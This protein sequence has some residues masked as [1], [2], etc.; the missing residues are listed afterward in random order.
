M[1][2]IIPVIF[3]MT[4]SLFS[5]GQKAPDF[6]QVVDKYFYTLP[7]DKNFE[8]WVSEIRADTNF[9][10]DSS[11]Y[12]VFPNDSM[13]FYMRVRN[14]NF[15]SPIPGSSTYMVVVA[16]NYN[17]LM[18]KDKIVLSAFMQYKF[19]STEESKK[20]IR[21]E[22]KFLKRQVAHYFPIKY[23]RNY[24]RNGNTG[25]MYNYYDKPS[26]F[27]QLTLSIGRKYKNKDEKWSMGI[28][29]GYEIIPYEN[30]DTNT[31]K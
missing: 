30:V 11:V 27:P 9:I 8:N 17:K 26:S 29:I 10:V 1:K 31:S 23:E 13:F 21:K 7:E 20:R 15:I 19:D 16:S 28:A 12:N 2:K 6:H 14:K 24:S 22:Y 3:I 5:Y 25:I 18:E 4:C